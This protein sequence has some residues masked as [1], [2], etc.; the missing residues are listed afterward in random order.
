MEAKQSEQAYLKAAELIGQL[1]STKSYA[2]ALSS[3]RNMESG[4]LKASMFM[5]I[6]TALRNDEKIEQA[7]SLLD[8]AFDELHFEG[9]AALR[10]STFALLSDEFRQSGKKLK[11]SKALSEARLSLNKIERFETG[12]ELSAVFAVAK[13]YASAGD[14][15]TAKTVAKLVNAQPGDSLMSAI[16]KITS[17]SAV[18][19]K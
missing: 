10:A 7:N 4:F 13:S 6:A 14:I 9:N 5:E 2:E 12:V 19:N 1:I 11:A 17:K 16:D 15:K 3:A 18:E 8:A